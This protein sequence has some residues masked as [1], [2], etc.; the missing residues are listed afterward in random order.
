AFDKLRLTVAGLF[1]LT[2]EKKSGILSFNWLQRISSLQQ[3]LHIL[4]KMQHALP[5]LRY[6]AVRQV[7]AGEGAAEEQPQ[8][9]AGFFGGVFVYKAID[10]GGGIGSGIRIGLVEGVVVLGDVGGECCHWV[11]S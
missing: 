9:A 8:L 3:R 10:N 4:I 5:L 1:R 7:L 6:I 11:K 2:V